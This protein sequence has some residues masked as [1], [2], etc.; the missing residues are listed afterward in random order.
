MILLQQL[1]N[2]FKYFI[3]LTIIAEKGKGWKKL[4]AP[5]YC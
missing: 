3:Y 5:D 1:S 4:M 2:S